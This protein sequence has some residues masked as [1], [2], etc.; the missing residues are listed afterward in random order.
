[1]Y[2]AKVGLTLPLYQHYTL[3]S[4]SLAGLSDA[5]VR[6]MPTGA[7]WCPLNY[8][9]STWILLNAT[10]ISY[11]CALH[12]ASC[13]GTIRGSIEQNEYSV[14]WFRHSLITVAQAKK[15]PWTKIWPGRMQV[16]RICQEKN[17]KEHS[18]I[19]ISRDA[20]EE[21]D[22]QIKMINTC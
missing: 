2:A 19:S 12:F 1:M 16:A 8:S 15:V 18:A 7:P 13:L 14:V 6:A 4:I 20:Q 5:W 10:Q 21:S 9:E 11:I 3:P 17:L 22:Q